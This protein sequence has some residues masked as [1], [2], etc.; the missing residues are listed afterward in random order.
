MFTAPSGSDHRQHRCRDPHCSSV[1]AF[2][3]AGRLGALGIVYR[4]RHSL[5]L[6]PRGIPLDHC[7]GG[8]ACDIQLGCF[9][10]RHLLICG[11]Q[12]SNCCPL[13]PRSCVAWKSKRSPRCSSRETWSW[14][15][16]RVSAM[17]SCVSL[18]P[19]VSREGHFLSEELG[20]TILNLLTAGGAPAP[21]SV[22]CLE[23]RTRVRVLPL[24]EGIGQG[25][26]TNLL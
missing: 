1:C 13:P 10:F 19:C 17:R 5:W 23:R 22:M 20:C 4:D 11:A 12:A 9:S 3:P 18:L 7:R 8:H 26:T 24:L 15:I 6:D 16:P 25:I 21:V 2:S 14:P